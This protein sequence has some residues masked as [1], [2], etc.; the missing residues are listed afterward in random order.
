[1]Q[2]W[3]LQDQKGDDW[4]LDAPINS[5]PLIHWRDTLYHLGV[6]APARS[7]DASI[8]DWG[9]QKNKPFTKGRLACDKSGSVPVQSISP[10]IDP[11][12]YS[13]GL[14]IISNKK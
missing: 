12:D 6:K 4:H 2:R 8:L 13:I 14:V 3:S 10:T 11:D 1:M 9:L 7:T 5:A